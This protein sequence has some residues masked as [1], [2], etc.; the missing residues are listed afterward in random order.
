MNSIIKAPV[1][2][3]DVYDSKTV[4]HSMG[5]VKG[6][7]FCAL[8]YRKSGTAEININGQKLISRKNFVTFTPKNQNYSTA[9]IEDTHIIAVH[10]DCLYDAFLSTPFLFEN[11]NQYISDLFDE[12]FESYSAT[13]RYNYKTFSLFYK[14]IDMVET[15]IKTSVKTKPSSRILKAKN[16]IDR[17][18]TDNDF[19]I[20]KLADYL[21]VNASYLRREFKKIYFVSPIAYM[22][23]VRMKNAISMLLSDYYSIEEIAQK[24]G[25]ASVSYFIQ[26]FNK[27]KGCSPNKYK[28]IHFDKASKSING[29][30]TLL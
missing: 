25:Y 8:T 11:T 30:V 16:E 6:R 24:C 7:P 22:Q 3:I 23:K 2:S 20:N 17:R 15:H 5:E 13:D 27:F 26:A 19:N 28:Q 4:S 12:I 14:L 9:I 18:Y 29:D 10:F 21:E 1:I